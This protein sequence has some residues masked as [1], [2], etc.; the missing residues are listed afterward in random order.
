[1]KQAIRIVLSDNENLIQEIWEVK[2]GKR[3]RIFDTVIS[4][5][6]DFKYGHLKIEILKE[7]EGEN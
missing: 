3:A 6:K 5:L 7:K 1:M 2:I 4:H